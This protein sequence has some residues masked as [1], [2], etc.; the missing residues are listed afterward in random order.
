M[1][2]VDPWAMIDEAEA[3]ELGPERTARLRTAVDLLQRH[4]EDEPD[5]RQGRAVALA[6]LAFDDPLELTR[7]ND[8]CRAA[9][10]AGAPV[11]L[12]FAHLAEALLRAG[13]FDDALGACT[14]VDIQRLEELDLHWRVVRLDEIRSAA[15]VRLGRF[16][17]AALPIARVLKELINEDAGEFL[18]SPVE[19]LGAL[20]EAANRQSEDAKT[21]RAI[22][23]RFGTQLPVKEWFP[24]ELAEEIARIAGARAAG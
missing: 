7:A 3:L 21:A 9:Q 23:G 1:S 11:D 2:D 14:E 6:M 5:V 4:A 19:L 20:V 10:M 8:A 22:I 15:L 17:E 13:R 18:P 24:E 16:D 12:P